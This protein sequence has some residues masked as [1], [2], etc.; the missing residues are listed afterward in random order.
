MGALSYVGGYSD[1]DSD[2]LCFASHEGAQLGLYYEDGDS[3]TDNVVDSAGN[4]ML[5]RLPEVIGSL[6]LSW[7][8][9]PDTMFYGG[10]DRS[11]RPPG[12]TITPTLISAD[13]LL[14][15]SETSDS[16]EL[17]FKSTFAE[18]RV[19][20][21]GA[22]FWQQFDGY[23]ARA[24]DVNV[25]F[26]DNDGEVNSSTRV[27]GG[28]SYTDSTFDSGE[29]NPC[30]RALTVEEEAAQLEIATCDI[31]GNRISTQPKWS[32]SLNTEYVIPAGGREWYLRGLYNFSSK[33]VDEL[34][35]GDDISSYNI[36]SLWAGLRGADSRWDINVWAKN[37][38][39]TK[40]K[41]VPANRKI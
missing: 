33:R 32:V 41:A 26:Y 16:L 10:Y 30:N 2:N 19:R 39:D 40:K 24:T 34:V 3:Q 25:T 1:T 4:C 27:Q 11:Y 38:F 13:S 36:T 8:M 37:I 6:K 17:G 15:D 20:I 22:V 7:F 12:A 21:N 28:V 35:E 31:G 18:G 5:Y 9:T 14:F 23:L 29:Q